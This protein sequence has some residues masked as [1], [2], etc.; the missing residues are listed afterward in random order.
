[1]AALFAVP[2]ASRAQGVTTFPY[3]CDFTPGFDTTV[4]TFHNSSPNEWAFGM[5]ANNGAAGSGA[6]YVSND[7]GT[8]TAYTTNTACTS[9]VSLTIVPDAAYSDYRISFDWKCKGEGSWDYMRVAV[10]DTGDVISPAT[11]ASSPNLLLRQGS[12]DTSW[13]HVESVIS[14][15]AG[16]PVQLVFLWKNDGSAGTAPAAIVDNVQIQGL[17]CSSPHSPIFSN[18]TL[19][20]ADLDFSGAPGGTW[21][22]EYSTEP[23]TPGDSGVTA[24]VL[25]TPSYSFTGLNEAT[26][27]YY[28]I[29]GLCGADT[30]PNVLTGYFITQCA[31]ISTLPYSFGFEDEGNFVACWHLKHT[32]NYPY[33]SSLSV[34][35]GSRSLFFYVPTDTS[36]YTYALLPEVD[37]SLSSLI[38]TFYMRTT[39][40]SY[41]GEVQIGYL[42]D[43]ADVSSFVP[44]D[45]IAPNSTSWEFYTVAL[46]NPVAGRVAFMGHNTG[47]GFTYVY[48]DDVVLDEQST[49]PPVIDLAASVG[50]GMA[51]L[52]WGVNQAAAA[53]VPSG[54]TITYADS[55]GLQLTENS[56]SA[57]VVLVGLAA[58]MAYTATVV[59]N[60]SDDDGTGATIS[61]VT[62]NYSCANM[63]QGPTM[64][65]GDATTTETALNF[66]INN[67]YR[68]TYSQQLYTA[69]EMGDSASLLTGISFKYAHTS[70]STAK[71]NVTLYLVNTE[72]TSLAGS[73]VPYNANTFVKVYEGPLNCV[74]GWNY[75]PFDTPFAYDGTSNLLLVAW[76]NSGDYDGSSY[77]FSAET[78]SGMSRVSNTD[79]SPYDITS[80]SGGS[81]GVNRN[82]VRFTTGEC[83]EYAT[84]FAPTLLVDSLT[85]TDAYL[86]VVD[87][88]GTGNTYTLS[89]RLASGTEWTTVTESDANTSFVINGLSSVTDYV[90]RVVSSSC[91]VPGEMAI[92]TPCGTLSLPYYN[93][94]DVLPPCWTMLNTGTYSYP[95]RG[96]ATTDH[97]YS[98]YFYQ[99][100]NGSNSYAVMPAATVSLDSVS[101]YFQLYKSSSTYSGSMEVGVMS[102]PE[103]VATFVP[104]D[105]ATVAN[106]GTWT[107]FEV[108][109]VG[110]ADSGDHIA[111]RTLAGGSY[112]YLYMDNVEVSL[113]PAC[114]N[115]QR[116]Y[117]HN[118]TSFS[119]D[120]TWVDATEASA[121]SHTIFYGTTSDIAVADSVTTTAGAP[122][123]LT[124]LQPTTTYY[125]WVRMECAEGQGRPI[126]LTPFTTPSPCLNVENLAAQFEPATGSMLLT[127]QPASTGDPATAYV[128]SYKS[129]DDT[130][131][132]MDTVTDTYALLHGLPAGTTYTVRVTQVCDTVGSPESTVIVSAPGCND[133]FDEANST[134][135]SSV[136]SHSTYNYGISQF[137]YTA[138]EMAHVGDT[139]T[140]ISFMLQTTSTSTP[141]NLVV[142]A[143][144]TSQGSFAS[145]SNYVPLDSLTLVTAAA[146]V[147][148]D[149]SAP[150]WKEITFSA[151]FRRDPAKNLVIMIDDNTGSWSGSLTWRHTETEDYR[152]VY[153]YGDGTNYDPTAPAFAY[154]TQSVPFARFASNCNYANV[155]CV[156]PFAMQT[157]STQNSVSLQ[158]FAGLNE[159]AWNV[160]YRY[161]YDTSYTWTNVLTNTPLTSTTI[162]GLAVGSAYQ[163]R[164]MPVCAGDTLYAYADVQTQCG[165]VNVPYV[166][167]FTGINGNLN[168]PCWSYGTQGDDVESMPQVYNYVSVGY[169][170][171]TF[172]GTYFMLPA[173]NADLRDLT[174]SFSMMA[175]DTTSTLLVGVSANA[176][177]MVSFAALDTVRATTPRVMGT[178]ILN[179]ASYNDSVGY[180]TFHNPTGQYI[181]V[182][183]IEVRLSPS[184]STPSALTLSAVSATT[185]DIAWTG[186]ASSYVVEYGPAGF[187]RGTGTQVAT[188]TPSASLTGLLSPMRYDVYVAGVCAGGDTT[189]WSSSLTFMTDCSP[190]A[191]LPYT[192]DFEEPG[193]PAYTATGMA[194]MC[195]EYF[196][197]NSTYSSASYQP[198]MYIGNN[199]TQGG[200]YSLRLYGSAVT[201]LPEVTAAPLDTVMLTFHYTTTSSNYRLQVGV[202]DSV[203]PGCE[204]SFQVLDEL[205]AMQEGTYQGVLMLGGYT[206]TSTHI[207]LRN[208]H[209]NGSGYA[210]FYLDSLTVGY[211]PDCWHVTQVSVA[212][213][214]GNATVDWRDMTP[215]TSYLLEYGPAGFQ[216]GTGTLVATTTHPYQIGG[217]ASTTAYEV[218]VRSICQNGGDTTEAQRAQFYTEMCADALMGS[219]EGDSVDGRSQYWLHAY[220]NNSASQ[221]LVKASEMPA[222]AQGAGMEVQF[223]SVSVET[224]KETAASYYDSVH[225]YMANTTR[226]HFANSTDWDSVDASFTHVFSGLLPIVDTGWN[227]IPLDTA[228]QWDGTSNV[229]V[230]VNRTYGDYISPYHYF[231]YSNSNDTAGALTVYYYSDNDPIDPSHPIISNSYSYYTA[232]WR[233]NMRLGSCGSVCAAPAVNVS[234]L[235]YESATLSGTGSANNYEVGV[236]SV[237]EATWPADV[238]VTG[239]TYAFD[240]LAPAT[241]YAYRVRALC[242]SAT[243]SEYAEGTF[244][245]DS[246]PCFAPTNL[247][248][249]PFFTFAEMSWT[250]GGEET[251]WTL[252][253][254]NTT[255]DSF[256]SV[257]GDP[258]PIEGLTSGVTYN[259]AVSAL[260]GGI[261]NSPYSDTISFTTL[262]CDAVSGVQATVEGSNATLTWTAGDNNTGSFEVMYGPAG[263]SITEGTSVS[264]SEA[265]ATLT[266]LAAGDYEAVVRA[267]CEANAPSAWSDRVSFSV[268]VGIDEASANAIS[269]YP[270]PATSSAT[271]SVRGVEGMVSIT[272]IDMDGRVVRSESMEC[273]A[274]CAKTLDVERLASGSYFVRVQGAGLDTVRKLVIK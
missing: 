78:S 178:H 258:T 16:E 142:Y 263:F 175:P 11:L 48:I 194:P 36:K 270:N 169:M 77:K 124:G 22:L 219:T 205:P 247:S 18:V 31:T 152:T 99:S 164:V 243:A 86:S 155:T 154:R 102:D 76:D 215:A 204:A 156:A 184:C 59:P 271:I 112:Q 159:T 188:T 212:V 7:G 49:C 54:Y 85:G 227:V 75:F 269:I 57:T 123:T 225:I 37:N 113:T 242:D 12:A 236:K 69:A 127:W 233:V 141:R 30:A 20:A 193:L 198:Q 183:A 110:Y 121:T 162:S 223:L 151:P 40:T 228:F 125:V 90:V 222:E 131:W 44:V 234:D 89:Y 23:F 210:Y 259:A 143:G 195:W 130:A 103:D 199:T 3:T 187:I 257:Y 5:A 224:Y 170:C 238:A 81:S 245:T 145:A 166:Q 50:P 25:T 157:G 70:P 229:V 61:F 58:G 196:M 21:V 133:V 80:V 254:W 82:V 41:A 118:V 216:P 255:F 172:D 117:A 176:G 108:S 201:V 148:L 62:P 9:W 105:T 241:T 208:Y 249:A 104:V 180:I 4:W 202:V 173:M 26:L 14:G 93:M 33:T 262:L 267:K 252:H 220:Y 171:Q 147:S 27:Y 253:V 144:Q 248:A 60:C 46:P 35:S 19:D 149:V 150:G 168:L 107:S 51:V 136:P 65:L 94:F 161:L 163:V 8:T 266:G 146:G 83:L 39:S 91:E 235:T 84:C 221:T 273:A 167:D 28:A 87:P 140:G 34:H 217:L 79:A 240:G 67:F 115:M 55:N 246:L 122:Y 128:V 272:V 45:T 63:Q 177:D 230:F 134:T 174:I 251:E 185:A 160:D 2:W 268:T 244:T 109:F 126:M 74:Q 1:M 129:A 260:C 111:F 15:L 153:N 114:A 106:P 218:Y 191:S 52:T 43:T 182:D 137:I 96:S 197:L 42:P 92:T 138:E 186:D 158:W 88:N 73:Y 66:P 100:S 38:L 209:A 203:A 119:A 165:A 179:L 10:M 97:G 53:N 116:A 239:T 32:G 213:D 98:L 71:S 24:E 274:D 132:T 206:G 231:N 211:M 256:Y 29:T 189:F 101:L 56:D 264:A 64:E 95:Q 13:S 232:D 120:I 72:V 17:A 181:Y 139:L 6:L 250:A 190:I 207:A 226:T 200:T 265:S 237:A 135:M 68:Y 47:T 214:G 261:L 192:F